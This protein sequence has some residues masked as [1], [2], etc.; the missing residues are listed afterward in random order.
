MCDFGP[1]GGYRWGATDLVDDL[2]GK[3]LNHTSRNRFKRNDNIL[4][5]YLSFDETDLCPTATTKKSVLMSPSG[6]P[7]SPNA[8]LD[9]STSEQAGVRISELILSIIVPKFLSYVTS[10]LK[11]K[12]IALG[13]KIAKH[14]IV[15]SVTDIADGTKKTLR[16]TGSM[17]SKR[18]PVHSEFTHKKMEQTS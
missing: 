1:D 9:A 10:H 8:M 13:L 3:L 14:E 16:K 12:A 17:L 11:D 4:I 5:P 2:A 7:T 15:G 18:S 6:I